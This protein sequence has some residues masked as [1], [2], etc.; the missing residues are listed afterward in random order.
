MLF[1]YPGSKAKLLKIILP[2]LDYAINR[3]K[4]FNDVF[5]GGGSV[6]VEVATRYKNIPIFVNDLN[7]NLFNFFE[8]ALK[9]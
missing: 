5:V 2:K 6:A 4:N 3:H 1:R 9:L 8:L 7:F